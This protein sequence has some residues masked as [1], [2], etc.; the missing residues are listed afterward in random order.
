MLIAAVTCCNPLYYIYCAL[1]RVQRLPT[2]T[3]SVWQTWVAKVDHTKEV[4]GKPLH[5]HYGNARAKS[6][7]NRNGLPRVVKRD[8]TMAAVLWDHGKM[9]ALQGQKIPNDGF[10][11]IEI[12]R[13]S[14]TNESKRLETI[15]S[16]TLIW[17]PKVRPSKVPALVPSGCSQRITPP[18]PL[19]WTGRVN[20]TSKWNPMSISKKVISTIWLAFKLWSI[21][22]LTIAK[23]VG[24]PKSQKPGFWEMAEKRA[25]GMAS[26]K[27]P[28]LIDTVPSAQT[29]SSSRSSAAKASASVP[30]KPC[31][32]RASKYSWHRRVQWTCQVWV[33]RNLEIKTFWELLGPVRRA[34]LAEVSAT[35]FHF[36]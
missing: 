12:T 1:Q 29:N 3:K 27:S 34:V 7:V 22:H 36:T 33:F 35:A 8:R 16:K 23:T 31:T 4:P 24:T 20:P 26:A 9:M 28:W 17:E 18:R 6:L 10:E 25:T 32:A 15:H 30:F 5:A 13:S 21:I 11:S 19:I 2:A 14:S